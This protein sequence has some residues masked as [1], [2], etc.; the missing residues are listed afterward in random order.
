V[1]SSSLRRLLSQKFPPNMRLPASSPR[2]GKKKNR[3]KERER[4]RERERENA[5]AS[6]HADTEKIKE[7]KGK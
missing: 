3:G 1:L 4:E 7:R 6:F 2:T 5:P